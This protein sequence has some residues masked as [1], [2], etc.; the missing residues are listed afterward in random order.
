[1]L[2]GA[3]EL[4]SKQKID[5]IEVELIIGK[6]VGSIH[7]LFI[8]RYLIINRYWLVALSPDGRFYNLN[9]TILCL[10]E[11]QFDLIYCSENFIK[12]FYTILGNQSCWCFFLSG[13]CGIE[14]L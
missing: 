4:L 10:I 12:I 2:E 13:W 9:R 5:I 14:T 7:F 6:Y 8:E 3:K 11:L 1:M